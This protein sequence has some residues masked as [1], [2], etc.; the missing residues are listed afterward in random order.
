MPAIIR[1]FRYPRRQAGSLNFGLLFPFLEQAKGAMV[2]TQ[3]DIAN[4]NA[5]AHNGRKWV[6][7]S[8]P[9]NT[10]AGNNGTVGRRTD[11][12]SLLGKAVKEQTSCV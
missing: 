11:G 5:V 7:P 12:D 1:R 4:I 8:R 3:V 9:Y 2:H 6:S 10:S